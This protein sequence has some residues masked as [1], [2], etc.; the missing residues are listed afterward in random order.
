[1]GSVHTPYCCHRIRV[2]RLAA[3]VD[4]LQR[5]LPRVYR[6]QGFEAKPTLP[7]ICP[8]APPLAGGGVETSW[9][10]G[11]RERASTFDPT[12]P[13]PPPGI[14]LMPAFAAIRPGV[15]TWSFGVTMAG[16]FGV[17]MAGDTLMAGS[18]GVA[19][20]GDILMA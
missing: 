18:F 12:G 2:H 16:S 19:M 17:A 5:A 1:M 7:R 6:H 13:S 20:A 9:P 14:E 11:D 10:T 8:P 3:R 15:E 4:P